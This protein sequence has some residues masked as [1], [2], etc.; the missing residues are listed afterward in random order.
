MLFKNVGVKVYTT[1]KVNV[2]LNFRGG[3]SSSYSAQSKYEY[4]LALQICLT[5]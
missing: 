2:S 4:L 3:A 5:V 1:E